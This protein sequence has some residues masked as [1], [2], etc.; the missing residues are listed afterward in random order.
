MSTT[1]SKQ[2]PIL[3]TKHI[4]INLEYGRG[5]AI[6]HIP[7]ADKIYKSDL[8]KAEGLLEKWS[9]FFTDIGLDG[10]YAATNDY[11]ANKLIE[12][13]GFTFLGVGDGMKVYRYESNN[14]S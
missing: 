4:T 3:E 6:L 11:R 13:L 7:R 8:K 9:E 5:F 14:R 2:F 1:D 10:P 12:K